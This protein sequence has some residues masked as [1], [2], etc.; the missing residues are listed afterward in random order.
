MFLKQFFKLSLKLSIFNMSFFRALRTCFRVCP[1]SCTFLTSQLKKLLVLPHS[2]CNSQ[3]NKAALWLLDNNHY[4]LFFV[5][6]VYGLSL[7]TSRLYEVSTSVFMPTAGFQRKLIDSESY[8]HTQRKVQ[9]RD[10]SISP[11]HE[12]EKGHCSI[13]YA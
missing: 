1:R 8:F 13:K 5:C 3:C 6:V 4:S 10:S 11:C 7:P 2:A 9:R 12:R